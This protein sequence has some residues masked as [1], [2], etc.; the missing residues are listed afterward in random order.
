MESIGNIVVKYP[1]KGKP[2]NEGILRVLETVCDY[3]HMT[4]NKPLHVNVLSLLYWFS[5]L[6][7]IIGCNTTQKKEYRMAKLKRNYN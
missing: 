6:Q 4:S 5:G 1:Q 7:E 2:T 3:I